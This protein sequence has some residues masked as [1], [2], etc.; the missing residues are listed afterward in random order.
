MMF[1]LRGNCENCNA[2]LPPH[3]QNAR[4]CTFECTFCADCVDT[5]LHNVCPNCTG[6]FEVR[7]IRPRAKLVANPA[8]TGSIFN[9]VDNE[10]QAELIAKYAYIPPH[11]R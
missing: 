2:A 7:P 1:E 5:V 11:L 9:P 3:A 4:I 6:G 8:Q 10:K